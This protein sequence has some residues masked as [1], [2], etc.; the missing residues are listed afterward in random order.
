[1]IAPTLLL[2]ALAP[3][4]TAIVDSVHGEVGLA[5]LDLLAPGAS[6]DLG[7]RGRVRIAYFSSCVHETVLGGHLRVGVTASV[8]VTG[9]VE[10]VTAD[11]DPPLTGSGAAGPAG[12][13]VLR[14]ATGNHGHPVRTLRLRNARPVLLGL[15]PGVMHRVCV[16][17]RCVQVWIDPDAT[18]ER[19]P[20]LERVLHPR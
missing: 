10:R 3:A 17:D 16:D 20:V 4:P 7:E 18:H 15:E 12:A 1:M 11:C 6:I 13:L 5:A 8:T 2:L 14:D 9:T 19:G